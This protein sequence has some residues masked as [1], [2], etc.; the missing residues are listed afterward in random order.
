MKPVG[1]SCCAQSACRPFLL[2][3]P[4]P[5]ISWCRQLCRDQ[6][7]GPLRGPSGHCSAASEGPV[8]PARS[9]HCSPVISLVING[10][11]CW[12]THRRTRRSIQRPAWKCWK[13]HGD[14]RR[15]SDARQRTCIEPHPASSTARVQSGWAAHHWTSSLTTAVRQRVSCPFCFTHLSAAFAALHACR[16]H[17]PCP[18][19]AG[20]RGTGSGGACRGRISRSCAGDLLA[21]AVLTSIAGTKDEAHCAVCCFQTIKAAAACHRHGPT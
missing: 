7:R 9:I 8:A 12:S 10:G 15:R 3:F 11:T 5:T 21:W 19:D 17:P 13:Q 18:S 6:L 14:S 20:S 4:P 1:V 2:H 16:A